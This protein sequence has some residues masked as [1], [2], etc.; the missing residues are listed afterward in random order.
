[1]MFRNL[2][3]AIGGDAIGRELERCAERVSAIGALE[4]E[5]RR[6]SDEALRRKTDEF[7][8]RLAEGETL[9]DL[10]VEAFAAVREASVRTTGLRPFDVQLVGGILLHE[11]K[12]AEMR[13][14]EGKTPG[15]SPP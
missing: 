14:G 9:D 12:I 15:G 11:G 13:T 2:R 6:L 10:L 1:M 8:R 5:L 4:P 7:R 3:R